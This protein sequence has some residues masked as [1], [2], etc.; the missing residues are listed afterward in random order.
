MAHPKYL[1]K[2]HYVMALSCPTKLY[3]A[4]NTKY[5]NQK[6]DD[7][8]LQA[9]A[10]GGHQV[11]ALAKAYFPEGHDI[12]SIDYDD[13]L[14]QTSELLQQE[15]VT[16]FEPAIQFGDY[17]VRIDILVKKG[18]HF[19]IYEVKARSF[20]KLKH[21]SFFNQSGK[22]KGQINSGWISHLNDAAF[23][24]YVLS[25]SIPDASIN[26]R[27]MLIDKNASCS[28]DGLNQKF[29]IARSDTGK[30]VKVNCKILSQDLSD[31]LLIKLPVDDA[32]KYIHE[33]VDEIGQDYSTRLQ[34]IATSLIKN[35]KIPPIIGSQC[36]KCEFHCTE[37][38][39]KNGKLSGFKSCW[40]ET[41]S[42]SDDDFEEDNILSIWDFRKIED[43]IIKGKVKFSELE[44]DDFEIKASAAPGLSRTERRWLQVNKGK[45]K[46]NSAYL[47]Y[48]GMKSEMKKWKFPLH[49]IDFETIASPLPFTK[50]RRPYEML[51]FQF[52]HHVVYEDG[53][54]EHYGEYLNTEKCVFPSFELMRELKAQL[55]NDEGSIFCYAN[56]ENSVLNAIRKQLKNS[57]EKIDDADEL[58]AFIECMTHAP[59]K[60]EESWV[61]ERDMVDM[62][63]LVVSY[64]YHPSMKGSN[65]IKAV[66]PAVLNSSTFLQEKYSKPIYGADDGIK[67]LNF[68]AWTWVVKDGESVK[69]PYKLLPTLFTDISDEDI[70]QLE[71]ESLAN[72]GAAMTAYARMQY[73]DTSDSQ[74]KEY[75]DGLLKYC[76]LDTLAMVM[77][78]ETWKDMIE[79]T[80]S[81]NIV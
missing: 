35:E 30:G 26:T 61:G 33:H 17:F 51:A 46:D 31:N 12:E 69:D 59:K 73:E 71:E 62:Q 2:S 3:Y 41:L 44:E 19:D 9:L 48:E 21:K 80:D 66:L 42:W 8:F 65:S 39:S 28:I 14:K 54:I 25:K 24:N 22:S 6:S 27:L 49:F 70:A 64:Y 57:P 56:H 79:S 75:R 53:T 55:E 76:E 77:I 81:A 43:F 58:C 34:Q 7:P 37:D 72:G 40:S 47:D 5:A 32:V 29:R 36:K 50:G 45:L 23:Q 67:S 74:I 11:G 13:A 52:S 60:A 16:I 78:Y 4:G 68:P 1:T 10:E 20:D 18:N 38:E 15:N 63:K